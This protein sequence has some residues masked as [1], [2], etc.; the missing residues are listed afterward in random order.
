MV[1]VEQI[2]VVGDRIFLNP[3]PL[4]SYEELAKRSLGSNTYR[5]FHKLDKSGLGAAHVFR[6]VL[7]Q[8]KDSI[9]R[10]IN[11]AGSESDITVLLTEVC[12]TLRAELKNH[13]RADQLN[14]FNKLRKPM[15]IVIQHMVAMGD[16][17]GD[18]RSKIINWLFLPL[19]SQ[20]FQSG[21]IFS[22]QEARNLGIKRSYT[23]KDIKDEIHYGDIQ[24]FLRE[25]SVQ[26][27]V[28]HRIYFD[29]IWNERYKSNGTN[30][31]LTNPR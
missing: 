30:L 19:D 7:L 8:N 3:R 6:E 21:F 26:L 23:F 10:N 5:G 28:K 29:L 11:G 12:D 18:A 9:V 1:S 25:K 17:F 24:N 15:D 31:F 2:N 27:G 22:D 16:V 20:I 13:I 4:L 14:S